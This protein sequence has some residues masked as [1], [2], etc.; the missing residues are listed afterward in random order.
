M[1]KLEDL[2]QALFGFIGHS[3][4][5]M[6]TKANQLQA[7][8]KAWLEGFAKHD[9]QVKLVEQLQADKAELEKKLK[10]IPSLIP[11]NWCDPLLTG[12]ASVVSGIPVSGPE[13]EE[14][15]RKIKDRVKTSIGKHSTSTSDELPESLQDATKV[16]KRGRELLDT[17][18]GDPK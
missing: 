12:G 13:V 17:N 3:L 9:S 15:L 18:T 11:T 1:D 7:E 4:D 6:I 16:L 5:E 10:F 14:L 2:S 8:N